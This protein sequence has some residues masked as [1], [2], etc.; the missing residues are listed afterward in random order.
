MAETRL[1]I[2]DNARLIIDTLQKNN[3]KAY[4]V[5]GCV[6]DQFLNKK[7]HDWDICT[8]ATPDE[9][10]KIF[11]DYHVIETGIKHGTVTVLINHEP[12]EVTT[13]RI[14][15]DYSDN[16]HPNS[17]TFTTDLEKDLARRDFTIN[18][19]AYNDQE[20]L[21]DPFNG[22]MDIYWN[23][24]CCVGNPYDR[25]K[26]DPLRILRALR[27]AV[28]E[29]LDIHDATKKAIKQRIYKL[30]EIAK[31]RIRDE[32]C[33]MLSCKH[34]GLIALKDYAF[35]LT[36]V[37]PELKDT[38]DFEQFNPYHD[39]TVYNHI[40]KAIKVCGT[41]D[42]ITRLTLLFH[43]IGK[44]HCFYDDDNNIRHFK[45]HGKVS[46]EMAE[47][48][49]IRLKFDNDT[50]HK[51]TELVKYHDSTID[52]SPKS[53]KRW[54]NRIGEEQ[55]RRLL[56]VRRADILAQKETTD[57]AR[58]EKID[59]IRTELDKIIKNKECFSRKDLAINGHH[60]EILTNSKPGKHIGEALDQILQLVI[61]GKLEN[62]KEALI[63]YIKDNIRFGNKT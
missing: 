7:P 6:R 9:V 28:T 8:S 53:I 41:T 51:V 16:R 57:S 39:Y 52:A 45:G 43:D 34:I 18:A 32:I 46:A 30:D 2:N 37:I 36:Y 10:I 23:F 40:V 44:P 47:A 55:F 38:I 20:G 49:M 31:E 15:G 29:H 12:F 27:F 21:I 54:L 58:I 22:K 17:V 24:L 33:K 50:K 35:I 56:D 5:G 60:I 48:I 42:L 14:D 11:K 25:I 1:K 63:D 61:D 13:F 19:M 4:I 59:R 26:E 3:H 62:T